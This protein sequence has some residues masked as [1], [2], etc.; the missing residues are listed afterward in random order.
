MISAKKNRKK[1][2]NK[3]DK[4]DKI[5]FFCRP[6]TVLQSVSPNYGGSLKGLDG[7]YTSIISTHYKNNQVNGFSGY[8][9]I[10][11]CL[12]DQWC[13]KDPLKTVNLLFL[14]QSD[15]PVSCLG[16]IPQIHI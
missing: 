11:I 13:L 15:Q 8:L 7:M 10:C 1:L 14:I 6:P 9:A 12:K 4:P 16:F 3:L 2:G 5:G